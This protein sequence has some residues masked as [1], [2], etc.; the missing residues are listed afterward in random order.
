MN[1]LFGKIAV[2]CSL[3]A[4]IFIRW[5]HGNRYAKFRVIEDRKGNLEIGLLLSAMLGTA[6]LPILWLTTNLFGFAEYSLYP[7]PFTLGLI[8]MLAG[9]WLFHRSHADLGINW[10][11][12]LQMRDNHSLVTS[13]VYARIRHPLY[14]SMFLLGTAQLMFLPNWIVGPAYLVGFGILYA[15]RVTAEERMMLDRFG[16]EYAAYMKRSGR[17]FPIVR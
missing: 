9:L 12:T 1:P 16:E 8:V 17:L 7:I 15:F 2:L 3:L 10:S 4:Y 11:V 6:I 13:G 5:P 14:A